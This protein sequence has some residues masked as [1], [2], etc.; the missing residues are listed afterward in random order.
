MKNT[1]IFVVLTAILFIV[2]QIFSGF[3]PSYADDGG[4]KNEAAPYSQD[5]TKQKQA[6]IPLALNPIFTPTPTPTNTPTPTKTSTPTN[7][8]SPTATATPS[9]SK[10]L[11]GVENWFFGN[12]TN[13]N[14]DILPLN[15]LWLRR[16]ALKWGEVETSEGAR[17]WG[18]VASMEAEFKFA[19]EKGKNIV[20]IIRYNPSW[21]RQ[22]SGSHCGPIKDTKI[23]AFA[24]FMKDAVAR[25]SKPPYN[26]MYYEIWNE[27]DAPVMDNSEVNFG[28]WGSSEEFNW[29]PSDPYFNGKYFSK[30]LK[31]VYPKMKEAN[32]NVKVM[33]G[34]L[35]MVCD[36]N[37]PPSGKDCRG[38]QYL[39]GIL[40]DGGK[41]YFDIVAFHA[42]DYYYPGSISYGNTNWNVDRYTGPSITPRADYLKS[43]LNQYGA[44][45]KPVMATEIG[46]IWGCDPNCPTDPK[47]DSNFQN[48]KAYYLIAAYAA[49][50][51]SNL[52][53]AIWYT[54]YDSWRY[55]GLC[56]NNGCATRKYAAYDAMKFITQ[57]L[58]N[59][60]GG[61]YLSHSDF[62]IYKINTVS[63]GTVWVLWSKDGN[64]HSY[65]F[66]NTPTKAYNWKGN[67]ISASKTMTIGVSPVYVE[68]A[69]N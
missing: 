54:M 4:T 15:P 12:D 19:S 56:D 65:T 51:E 67:T 22:F 27:P 6:F 61:S 20:L 62:H 38:S 30:V 10:Y 58:G 63:K 2:I 32:S 35:L 64:N 3:S 14:S 57:E 60:T 59:T 40:E 55:N 50:I 1:K 13:M 21:A 16:N 24:N 23:T 36:P 8:P 26:V 45:S 47:L 44:G 25:Y 39:Q 69:G 17:N 11:F 34:G 49:A 5:A 48:T 46:L 31:A 9:G 52:D 41:N 18:N 7:T 68:G 42:Y 29:N 53:A 43:V 37:N 33:I 28:C 66:P